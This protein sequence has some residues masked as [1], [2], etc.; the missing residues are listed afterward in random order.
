M[1]P[2]S[3]VF[4]QEDTGARKVP[5]QHALEFP[6][7]SPVAVEVSTQGYGR[8]RMQGTGGGYESLEVQFS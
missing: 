6:A 5:G 7:N 3:V 4:I 8:C 1:G 2:V